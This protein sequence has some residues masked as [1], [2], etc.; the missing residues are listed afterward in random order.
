[1]RK[2]ILAILEAIADKGYRKSRHD[3]RKHSATF[4]SKDTVGRLKNGGPKRDRKI[5]KMLKAGK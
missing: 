2:L 4:G 5:R 3:R 1:M